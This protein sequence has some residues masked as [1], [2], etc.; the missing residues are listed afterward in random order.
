[1][2]T[3][4][5]HYIP[6]TEQLNRI[7]KKLNTLI[8]QEAA[9]MATLEDLTTEVQQNG[10]AVASAVT[11]LNG[12]TQQLQDAISAND[13]AAIQALA[14]SLS[15]NTQSLADAVIANTPAAP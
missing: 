9:Q 5:H 10:D 12:L 15:A 8:K 13:P 7:E 6:D 2:F 3:F 4:Y 14:D 1:M 11:L